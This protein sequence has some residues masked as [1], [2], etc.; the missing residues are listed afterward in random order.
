MNWRFLACR[1][2]VQNGKLMNQMTWCPRLFDKDNDAWWWMSAKSTPKIQYT[3]TVRPDN[4]AA[5]LHDKDV[6]NIRGACTVSIWR[7]VQKKRRQT[8]LKP[9]LT[10]S[11]EMSNGEIMAWNRWMATRW[12]DRSINRVG[13][14]L[15]YRTFQYYLNLR[16]SVI[17]LMDILAIGNKTHTHT[18]KNNVCILWRI[19]STLWRSSNT[20][21][22][23]D[24]IMQCCFF[25]FSF[26][27][28]FSSLQ[29]QR[30]KNTSFS[31]RFLATYI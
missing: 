22:L 27:L 10:K 21:T 30:E 3:H 12:E 14:I 11:K 24:S 2:N 7:R 23:F 19:F 26:F 9:F 17:F 29:H 18:E 1:D 4:S 25:L 15:C 13:V 28:L 16:L 5:W 8:S 20:T 31:L 6:M